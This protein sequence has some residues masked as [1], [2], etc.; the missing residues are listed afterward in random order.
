MKPNRVR[1]HFIDVLFVLT[2]FGVFICTALIVALMGV[3]VYRN[4]I[5]N[6][7][8]N[9]DTQTSI[10]YISTK[11]RQHD[12]QDSIFV[13]ALGDSPALVFE[14]SMD[15]GVYE[16]WVYHYE[17]SLWTALVPQGGT[18][19]PGYGT[20]IMKIEGF[21]VQQAR[22]NLYLVS[23]TDSTGHSVSLYIGTRS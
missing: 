18:I 20:A 9:F 12:M 17:G 16:T 7:N 4:I 2:L 1:R 15:G 22:D 23:T 14:E 21:T 10:T 3:N 8:R 19:E 11:V 5:S 6:M 13:E